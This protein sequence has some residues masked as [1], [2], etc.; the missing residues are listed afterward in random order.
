MTYPDGEHMESPRTSRQGFLEESI[1]QMSTIKYTNLEMAMDF[2][3]DTFGYDSAAYICRQTGRIY[4]ESDEFAADEEIPDDIEN[5]ALYVQVPDKRDL[6]LG[7]RLVMRFVSREI[8]GKYDQV[9]AIFRRKGAYSR[10]KELLDRDDLLEEWYK[11]EQSVTRETLC[12]W[13][14][15][16]G[17]TVEDG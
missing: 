1:N 2:A 10:Y 11:F 5:A 16:E 9:D 13:A 12:E 8:P 4:Y 15:D 3:S 14:E 7:K 17:F 6:D